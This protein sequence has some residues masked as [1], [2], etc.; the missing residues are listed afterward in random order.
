[1]ATGELKTRGN[2]GCTHGKAPNIVQMGFKCDDLVVRVVE[3]SKLE[4]VWPRGSIA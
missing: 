1:M 2:V 4:I 3:Y